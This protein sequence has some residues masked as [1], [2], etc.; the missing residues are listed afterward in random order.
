VVH[1]IFIPGSYDVPS[2]KH[3]LISPKY[4]AQRV[5]VQPDVRSASCLTLHDRAI[6]T[7]DN[8]RAIKT[9]P[10]DAQNVFTFDLAPGYHRFSAYCLQAK[11]NPVVNDQTPE[12]IPDSLEMSQEAK[13]MQNCLASDFLPDLIELEQLPSPSSFQLSGPASSD[14]CSVKHTTQASLDTR[15]EEPTAELLRMH[16]KFG[17][18]N[19]SR[20]RA[21]ARNGALPK[22]L[23]DCRLPVCPSCLY[24][25]AWRRSTQNKAKRPIDPARQLKGSGDCVSV[26]VLVSK[27]PGLVAQMKGW[28]TT[29]R[30][31]FACVFVNHFSDYTH[32]HLLKVQDGEEILQAKRSFEERQALWAFGS[33]TIMLPMVFLHRRPGLMTVATAAKVS[34]L[35]VSTL[36]TRMGGP[37]GKFN[38]YKN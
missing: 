28:I 7:W 26:D 19:F 21:I 17:H 16:Y 30:Y 13:S 25:K 6:L 8:G 9:V 18:V 23:A 27:T 32:L 4:W 35:L 5:N 22:P 37:S 12:T 10:T 33:S 34:H 31:Q 20:L 24:V 11:Y 1:D 3:R 29:R 36:T 38:L 14:S 2:G 15:R